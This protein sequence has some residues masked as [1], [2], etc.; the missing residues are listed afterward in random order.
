MVGLEVVFLAIIAEEQVRGYGARLMNHCKQQL[1]SEGIGYL[2]TYADND[3]VG[4]YRSRWFIGFRDSDAAKNRLFCQ[5]G[6]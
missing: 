1:K 2:L 4:T 5:A 3:A 6:V